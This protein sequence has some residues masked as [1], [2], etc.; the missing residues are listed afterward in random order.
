[1]LTQMN[2]PPML[3]RK[4]ASHSMSAMSDSDINSATAAV[5]ARIIEITTNLGAIISP[6]EYFVL[7][8]R[9]FMPRSGSILP[10]NRGT[11]YSVGNRANK[12]PE[13]NTSFRKD[14]PSTTTTLCAKPGTASNSSTPIHTLAISTAQLMNWWIMTPV[15]AAIPTCLRFLG[16]FTRQPAIN[17]AR[18]NPMNFSNSPRP[19]N[20]PNMTSPKMISPS[21]APTAA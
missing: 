2:H 5:T 13:N 6:N 21:A 4:S 20:C 15:I 11:R 10:Y 9:G 18:E 8:L 7:L 17:I 1:M 16:S 14:T 12:M 19:P 3:S